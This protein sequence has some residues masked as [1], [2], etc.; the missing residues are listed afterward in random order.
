MS[1]CRRYVPY[2]LTQV[3]LLIISNKLNCSKFTL[4]FIVFLFFCPVELWPL[5]WI[6]ILYEAFLPTPSAVAQ[7]IHLMYNNANICLDHLHFIPG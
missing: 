1:I 5:T 7:S 2:N 6:C 4:I 3:A